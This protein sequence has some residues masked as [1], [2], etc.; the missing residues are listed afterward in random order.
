[1][2]RKKKVVIVGAGM[3]GM[4]AARWLITN[5]IYNKIDVSILEGRSRIGGRI[6]T[7]NVGSGDV[8]SIPVDMGAAW[9]HEHDTMCN[10]ISIL[11][12]TL[13]TKVQVSD[14][15][16]V[17]MNHTGKPMNERSAVKIW[18]K[19]EETMETAVGKLHRQLGRT[20]APNGQSFQAFIQQKLGM[21]PT[22]SSFNDL[23]GA[24]SQIADVSKLNIQ[25]HYLSELEFQL[26]TS[27]EHASPY[28]VDTDWLYGMNTSEADANRMPDDEKDDYVPLVGLSVLL[29]GVHSG[30]ATKNNHMS[31]TQEQGNRKCLSDEEL[32]SQHELSRPVPVSLGAAVTHIDTSG[33]KGA[34]GYPCSLTVSSANPGNASSGIENDSVHLMGCDLIIVTVPLGVLKSPLLQFN[35][36]LSPR[37]QMAIKTCGFGRHIVL[38]LILMNHFVF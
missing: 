28:G 9:I 25:H 15:D 29:Q 35:P 21:P 20:S 14:G 23:S 34:D 26:G 22:S 19:T 27:L 36:A 18:E 8:I 33:E 31:C 6:H 13:G 11:A 24:N 1:M 38:L 16:G 17:V 3:A 32:G 7:I 2:E 12:K 30:E 37:K 10:P 4:S 5:D